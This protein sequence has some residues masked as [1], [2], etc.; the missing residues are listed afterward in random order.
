[1]LTAE[2]WLEVTAVSLTFADS[3]VE[4]LAYDVV[5]RW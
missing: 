3:N 1:M 5:G 4:W 2:R